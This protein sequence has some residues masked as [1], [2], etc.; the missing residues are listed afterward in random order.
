[1]EVH[2]VIRYLKPVCVA[3]ATAVVM[4]LGFGPLGCGGANFASELSAK[5]KPVPQSVSNAAGKTIRLP[6]D[7]PFSIIVNESEEK[8]AL[9]GSADADAQAQR[10]G[11]AHADARVSDGGQARATF[12][13]GHALKNDTERQ[14][15][16]HLTVRC[17]YEY[18]AGPA[19]RW[20]DAKV[21]LKLYARDGR[22]RLLTSFSLVQHSTE[23]GAAAS[24]DSKVL[25]FTLTLGPG[26]SV[27]VFLA[28]Q[29]EIDIDAGR[30]ARG[31]LKL[32]GLE[33]EVQPRPAAAVR[34]AGDEQD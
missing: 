28:G 16:L 30:S 24:K 2:L 6:Q 13:L 14:T 21:G 15:D 31:S 34:T 32:R 4:L 7:K 11:Q 10:D 9:D 8:A 18:E 5:D 3:G 1:M 33:M 17:G 27:N 19:S 12:Q 29:V 23:D 25:D 22:N 26:E 20:A